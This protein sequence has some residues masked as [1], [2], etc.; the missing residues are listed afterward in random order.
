VNSLGGKASIL[1]EKSFQFAVEIVFLA[2]LLHANFKGFRLADQILGSGTSIG[3]NI[4]E[5]GNAESAADFVHKLSI[6][7]KECDETVY[8]LDLL[9]QTE[10]IS[11]PL[12]ES[13]I[14]KALEL[15]KMLTSSIVTV[16]KKSGRLTSKK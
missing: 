13:L 11:K 3:A 10:R 16:K 14:S 8:W 1:Q 9:I 2:D 7:L 4:R 12:H 6:A 5:A 15:R